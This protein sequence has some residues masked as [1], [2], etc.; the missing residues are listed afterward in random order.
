MN[1]VIVMT[2]RMTII[3]IEV[4]VKAAPCTDQVS[5]SLTLVCHNDMELRNKK[6]KNVLPLMISLQFLPISSSFSVFP[7]VSQTHRV[8]GMSCCHL[9][10]VQSG[11]LRVQSQQ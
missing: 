1:K 8:R 5:S 6:K 4:R 3:L 2:L 11:Y 7:G 10:G 9:L